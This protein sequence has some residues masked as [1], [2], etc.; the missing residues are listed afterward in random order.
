MNKEQILEEINKTKEH[1]ANMEKMLEE[2]EYKKW[3]P[4]AGDEYY[5]VTSALKVWI[6]TNYNTCPDIERA[7]AYNCFRTAE[8]AKEEA[9]KILVRRMLEDIA[10]RLN[11]GQK[12]DWDDYNQSKYSICLHDNNN[13]ATGISF[14]SKTQGAVYCLSADFLDVAI[15]KISKERLMKYLRGE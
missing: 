15:Q 10:R 4:E 11:K 6:D 3:K 2:C 7:G 12:I 5:F 13:V 1:L 14:T 9:E 8:E